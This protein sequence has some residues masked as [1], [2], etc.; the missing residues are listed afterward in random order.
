MEKYLTTLTHMEANHLCRFRCRNHY[1]PIISGRYS[2]IKRCER[3]CTICDTK[4]VGDESHY[5][6]ICPA[7][8]K[9][10]ATYL[11]NRYNNGSIAE[12]MTILFTSEDLLT[13][14]NLSKFCCVI[15]DRFKPPKPSRPRIKRNMQLN[16]RQRDLKPKSKPKQLQRWKILLT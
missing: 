10:R 3:I 7:F 5:I 14:S 15:M 1:L 2:G 16:K 11:S 6:F 4:A 13:M 12:N 8:A 9:E